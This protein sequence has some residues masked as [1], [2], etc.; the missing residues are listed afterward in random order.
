[1]LIKTNMLKDKQ[2]GFSLL[3]VMIAVF[4]TA[5]GLVGILSLANISLR[6][7]S[8][9]ENRLIASGLAQEGIEIIRDMRRSEIEWDD[10]YNTILNGNYLVQYNNPNLISYSE[11]PLKIDGN[12]FYQYDNGSNSI[13]YRKVTLNKISA[14]EVKVVV[15]IK[16]QDSALIAEDRLWN[17][18]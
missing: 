9:G 6:A 13:F 2:K 5:V 18:K 4:I 10:W 11:I 12:N 16:W 14:D 3:E 7:S 1:M 17:W 15:E 8:F